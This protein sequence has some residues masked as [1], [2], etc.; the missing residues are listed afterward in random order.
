[1]RKFLIKHLDYFTI[2]L[3]VILALAALPHTEEIAYAVQVRRVCQDECA[4]RKISSVDVDAK[5]YFQSCECEDY[6]D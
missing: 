3:V 4:P 5:G 2:A 6:N 1:M